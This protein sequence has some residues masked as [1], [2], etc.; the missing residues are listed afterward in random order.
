MRNVVLCA[1]FAALTFPSFAAAQTLPM[2]EAEA[3]Q[4]LSD[5][6][7]RVRAIRAAIDLA[8]ADVLAAGRWPNPR[9]TIDRESAA[10]NT[11]YLTM[12]GQLL[13][14]TGQRSL[15]MQAASA[16]V[17]AAS[18]RADDAIRR[19]RADL[20]WTFARLA[21]AQA[22]ERELTS[23]GERLRQLSEI[24]SK[25]EAAGDAAGFDRLRAEREVLDVDADR[26]TAASE[27]AGAQ[28][29]LAAFFA[30]PVEATRIVA[31]V[32]DTRMAPPMP[33]VD[34]LMERAIASRGDLAAFRKEM[35]AANL[36]V[37]AADRRKL[38]EPEVIA[39]TKSSSVGDGDIGSVVT[40]QAVVPLFDRGKIER[41]IAA[42]RASQAEAAA[43]VFRLSLR[44][45]I[46]SLRAIVLERRDTAARY[47]ATAV[48][49]VDQLERIAQVSYD[50]GERGILELLDAYRTGA[51]AR[52]RQA[53]LNAAVR[54]AEIELEFVSGWEIP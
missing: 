9:F 15:Q 31:V 43:A 21:T 16:L 8:R 50:E 23:A 36:S 51:A 1:T 32:S 3:L 5:S 7:P 19:A 18:S 6:S 12:V 11:E 30:E 44:A 13:P 46:E 2:T 22:R 38:P 53:T 37:R 14:I 25:R 52:V 35:D 40:V 34:A 26:A 45:D 47:R 41:A 4:R 17:E 28:A 20:R 10:G 49:S 33:T 42:A 27:R 29:A 54:Q 24:L 48:A 39:G